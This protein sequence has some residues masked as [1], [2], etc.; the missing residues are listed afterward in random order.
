MIASA[1]LSASSSS[2]VDL[3]ARFMVLLPRVITHARITFRYLKCRSKKEEAIQECVSVA[4]KW[5]ARLCERGKDAA[6]FPV[7]FACL[8][9]KAVKCGRR[10]CSAEKANDVLSPRAQQRYGFTVESLPPSTR[11]C[12]EE[13]YGRPHGQEMLDTFE[14]RLRDNT[15]TPPPDAAAFRID[16]PRF[17]ASLPERDR[18]LAVFLSMGHSGKAAAAKFKV[19]QGRVTQLRQK[20]CREWRAF[21]GDDART[22]VAEA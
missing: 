20:W 10:V 13:L 8:V 1:A 11:T 6:D 4:W 22:V 9:V 17:F 7:A 16:W 5:F 21:E 3:H 14:E 12:V 18:D 19:S 15:V 2:A